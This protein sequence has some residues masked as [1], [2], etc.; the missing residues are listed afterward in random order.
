MIMANTYSRNNR[1]KSG[2]PVAI[3]AVLLLICINAP[4]LYAFM[5]A[6]FFLLIPVVL[7]V[8]FIKKTKKNQGDHSHNQ[9]SQKED[10]K[11]NA[12]GQVSNRAVSHTVH[13]GKAHWKQ[14]LDYLLQNGSI[15]REEYNTMLRQYKE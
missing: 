7:I 12:S 14:Q 5:I 1:G 13:S 3:I 8:L 9:I 11:V 4:E 6:I 10:F 2:L 15:D